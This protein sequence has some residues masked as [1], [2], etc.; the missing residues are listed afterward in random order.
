VHRDLKP[1]NLFLARGP[2]GDRVK[3]LDFGIS[4][5]SAVDIGNLTM[6]KSTTVMGSPLYMSPEQLKSS[7]NVD[8]R[9]DIWALGVILYELMTGSPPFFADSIAE[10]NVL[11]L[12]GQ[13]P[14]MGD[15]APSAPVGL[16]GVV[17]TCLQRD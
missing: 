2:S 11:V 1:S 3:V 7:K 10:L 15:S 5:M 13:A 14:W 16:C 12:S 9:A 17:A 6:T 4:K 8:A